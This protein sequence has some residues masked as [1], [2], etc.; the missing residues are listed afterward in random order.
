M[1]SDG[2][3]EVAA[4]SYFSLE[5][6]AR[7]SKPLYYI[8]TFNGNTVLNSTSR[9]LDRNNVNTSL[10]GNYRC[11]VENRYGTALSLHVLVTVKGKLV[12]YLDE[13]KAFVFEKEI[14]ILPKWF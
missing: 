4:E 9:F 2:K 13:E 12:Y 1:L 7:G 11:R 6:E 8:W 14:H 5:I 3:L 10:S